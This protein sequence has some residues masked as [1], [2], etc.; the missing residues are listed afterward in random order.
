MLLAAAAAVA[1]SGY[2]VGVSS[3][4]EQEHEM[5]IIIAQLKRVEVEHC[6]II[7]I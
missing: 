1:A 3:V 5:I 6:Y 2:F 7:G 4:L